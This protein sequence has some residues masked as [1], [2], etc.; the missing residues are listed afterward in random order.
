MKR[1]VNPFI[2]TVMLSANIL[3]RSSSVANK[4]LTIGIADKNGGAMGLTFTPPEE[5]G[6]KITKSGVSV[7]LKKNGAS[8]DENKEIEAYLM[9]LDVP[10]NPISGYVEQIKKNT[11]DGYGNDSRFKILALEVVP[12]NAKSQCARV[13][14]LLEDKKPLRTVSHE[15]IKLSEQYVLSCGSLK[16][17]GMGVEVR[18]YDRY[19]EPKKDNQLAEKANKIF[20]SVIID[21]K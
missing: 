15:H 7:S 5:D 12:D 2:V 8:A 9:N 17:K 6:W 13:H 4:P 3:A 10:I 21:D 19:Y 16:Y 18:Y 14:L 20:E 1:T 11:L